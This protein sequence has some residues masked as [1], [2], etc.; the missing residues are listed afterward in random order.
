MCSFWVWVDEK[1]FVAV[2]AWLMIYTF[3]RFSAFVK[4]MMGNHEALQI[5]GCF[6]WDLF[7]MRVLAMAFTCSE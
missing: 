7:E 5:R 1:V 2:E 4:R 6:S 3:R